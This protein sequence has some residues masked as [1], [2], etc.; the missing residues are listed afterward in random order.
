[1]SAGE[2]VAPYARLLRL[3]HIPRLVFCGLLATMPAGMQP[4]ALLLLAR[5]ATGSYGQA[6]I[7]V[8]GTARSSSPRW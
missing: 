7:V 4:L 5:E 1:M 2:F 6:S 3:P 8:G